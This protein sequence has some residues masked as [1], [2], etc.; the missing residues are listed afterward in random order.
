M[1]ATTTS[2]TQ[3]ARYRDALQSIP[4]PGEGGCHTALLGVANLARIADIHQDTAIADI[5]GAIPPGGRTVPRREVADAVHKAYQ[6]GS[7]GTYDR[8]AYIQS[9]HKPKVES[10][11]FWR[12]ARARWLDNDPMAELWEKSIVRLLDDPADD[13]VL[14]L[15]EMYNP[16]DLL[17]IGGTYDRAVPGRTL[18]SARDWINA[19]QS[20]HAPAMHICANPLSGREAEKKDGKPSRR[21]DAAIA[22]HRY[23]IVEFD[24][25]S[26]EDQACFFL[27]SRL[28]VAAIVDTGGKSLHG[29]IRVDCEDSRE[30]QR[31]VHRVFAEVLKPLGADGACRNASR[32]VRLPGAMRDNG[33]LQR[34][35]FLAPEGRRVAS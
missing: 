7:Q 12:D 31:D 22:A 6:D 14:F 32:L 4:A 16:S 11:A 29:W 33:N 17:F 15:R 5:L 13:A 28:P 1:N 19:M 25:R 20:G 2:D 30:W 27:Q 21:C 18:R 3:L 34:L 8:P 10:E 9:R 23:A 24:D 35:L 26:R